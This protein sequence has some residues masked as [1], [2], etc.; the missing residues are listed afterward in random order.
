MDIV[1]FTTLLPACDLVA[2]AEMAPSATTYDEHR[3]EIGLPEG[4]LDMPPSQCTPLECN[5]VFMNGG[6]LQFS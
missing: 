6:M 5:A 3:Y 2:N 1:L 4:P